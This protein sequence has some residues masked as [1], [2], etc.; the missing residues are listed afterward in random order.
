MDQKLSL[1]MALVFTDCKKLHHS[2]V[3]LGFLCILLEKTL[4][5]F[6]PVFFNIFYYITF[7][8]TEICYILVLKISIGNEISQNKLLGLS[9]PMLFLRACVNV[10]M[11]ICHDYLFYRAVVGHKNV[12]SLTE[13]KNKKRLVFML[14]P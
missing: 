3:L 11:F 12:D 13:T 7:T 9:P 2:A 5:T 1:S 8:V 4:S 10:C 6:V 14:R